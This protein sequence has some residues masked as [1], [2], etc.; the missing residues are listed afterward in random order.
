MAVMSTVVDHISEG[1]QQD[2]AFQLPADD[3]ELLR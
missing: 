3:G 2:L 1:E